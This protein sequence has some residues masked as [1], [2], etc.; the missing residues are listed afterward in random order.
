MKCLRLVAALAL[1][2]AWLVATSAI[3]RAD[4]GFMGA[5]GSSVM[6]MQ[7]DQVTMS[8]ERVDALIRGDQA[9][10]SCVFTFTNSGPPTTVLMGFPQMNSE[11]S[12]ESGKL[13]GFTAE[14]DGKAA[15]VTFKPQVE[16]SSQPVMYAGWYTFNVPFAAR[17]TRIVRNTY[18]GGLSGFSD[19]TRAF[20]YILH[21]GATWLGPIGRADVN[22]RWLKDRDVLPGTIHGMPS[23]YEVSDH[24]LH[25][26]FTNLEPT[27]DDDILAIFDPAKGPHNE[28]G[29]VEASSGE[30]APVRTQ[31][32][33]SN[34]FDATPIIDGD[35]ATAW[36]STGEAAGAWV[37]WLSDIYRVSPSTVGLGI[38]PGVAANNTDFKAHGRPKQ[39]MVRFAVRQPNATILPTLSAGDSIAGIFDHPTAGLAIVDRSITLKDSPTWQYL[40]LSQPA[41]AIGFQVI[42]QSVYPGTS[43][44]DVAISEVLFPLL[45]DDVSSPPGTIPLTGAGEHQWLPETLSLL[46]LSA[47]FAGVFLLRKSRRAA[48]KHK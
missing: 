19:G 3:T 13:L 21:T 31:W 36:R 17:Q 8:A 20:G 42:V 11:R 22:V 28:P 47:T 30:N 12:N 10:V 18:H 24:L 5:V 15:A 48:F 43:Y 1:A 37:G 33:V 14:V 2:G 9:S 40:R 38:L 32:S 4:D 35:P 44:N 26:H 34:A 39:V 41:D 45:P 23:G 29:T 46:G 25:W 6:P 16:N 7:N 27:T